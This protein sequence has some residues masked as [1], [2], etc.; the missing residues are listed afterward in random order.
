[1]PDRFVKPA[2]P[3][4]HTTWILHSQDSPYPA[5]ADLRIAH[6]C[7]LSP[8]HFPCPL[9]QAIGTLPKRNRWTHLN[10]LTRSGLGRSRYPR[11]KSWVRAWAW[12]LFNFFK[13]RCFVFLLAP[14]RTC[15][16]AVEFFLALLTMFVP[17]T[18]LDYVRTTYSQCG[19]AASAPS[20]W[21]ST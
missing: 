16:Y 20:G 19:A 7:C 15:G 11:A 14:I 8:S 6:R 21:I 9:Q 12:Y 17:C 10:P 2:D 13:T 18:V 5:H 4:L 1:M 3:Q